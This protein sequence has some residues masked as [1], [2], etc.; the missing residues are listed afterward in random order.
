[1][2]DGIG[3]VFLA[4]VLFIGGIAGWRASGRDRRRL[5]TELGRHRW[6][7]R[8]SAINACIGSAVLLVII[9]TGKELMPKRLISSQRLRP[10]S[11]A[12]TAHS[13]G[14]P[15]FIKPTC[16]TPQGKMSQV[17]ISRHHI[18]STVSAQLVRGTAR[19]TRTQGPKPLMTRRTFRVVLAAEFC[20]RM[21]DEGRA[22]MRRTASASVALTVMSF[23]LGQSVHAADLNGSI[24]V[25]A[26]AFDNDLLTAR[27]DCCSATSHGSG[28]GGWRRTRP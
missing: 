19:L 4:I 28:N 14:R 24:V 11:L 21:L 3:S 9:C 27:S 10:M 6:H 13:S 20:F 2:N 22:Q 23:C 1:M 15:E 25:P 5:W 26:A 16:R 12:E 17:G 7:C 8:Y 18:G